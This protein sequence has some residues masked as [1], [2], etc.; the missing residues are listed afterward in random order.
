MTLGAADLSLGEARDKG[1]ELALAV[2]ARLL[3]DSLE[4]IAGSLVA[5]AE[6]HGRCFERLPV[7]QAVCEPRFGRCEAEDVPEVAGDSR[8]PRCEINEDDQALS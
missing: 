5:D 2:R 3:I 6:A 4:P 8:R 7:E 1:D